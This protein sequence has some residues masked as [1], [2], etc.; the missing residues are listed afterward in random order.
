MLTKED[1][2]KIN[3]V[4]DELYRLVDEYEFPERVTNEEINDILF[5]SKTRL[6]DI[7][8]SHYYF[9]VEL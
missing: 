9:K 7:W 5:R 8:I 6:S 4:I 1:K 2:Q 3:C